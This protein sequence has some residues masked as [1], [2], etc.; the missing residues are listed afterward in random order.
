M[1][2]LCFGSWSRALKQSQLRLFAGVLNVCTRNVAYA[3]ISYELCNARCVV[4]QNVP[5]DTSDI[6]AVGRFLG[7]CMVRFDRCAESIEIGYIAT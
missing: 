6:N 2:K 5:F 4:L 7:C 3:P 1:Q